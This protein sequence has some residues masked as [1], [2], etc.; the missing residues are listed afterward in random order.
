MQQKKNSRVSPCFLHYKILK[1]AF[2]D[3]MKPWLSRH[4][5]RRHRY[6]R[7]HRRS[8]SKVDKKTKDVKGNCQSR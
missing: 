5:R 1:R 3:D 4:R 8:E 7:R 2:V 6:R